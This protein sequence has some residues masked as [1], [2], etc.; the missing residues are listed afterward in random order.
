MAAASSG[1]APGHVHA[2][3]D[4]R[5]LGPGRLRVE[6]SGEPP[7]RLPDAHPFY[8]VFP[9]IA[10]P[11]PGH[12]G[13]RE[14]NGFLKAKLARALRAGPRCPRGAAPEGKGRSQ[15]DPLPLLKN[16][17][18]W[19]S[20][21][22]K[23]TRRPPEHHQN[24]TRRPPEDHLLV[25]EGH[26]SP[27]PV[28]E[29]RVAPLPVSGSGRVPPSRHPPPSAPRSAPIVPTPSSAPISQLPVSAL[30]R[31][32]TC[33]VLAAVTL[34]AWFGVTQVRIFKEY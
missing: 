17:R 27:G 3:S 4:L 23:T 31:S 2:P 19:K 25:P 1:H 24:T 16:Q 28:A 6:P 22:E 14:Q 5:L 21:V 33:P 30:R 34:E 12:R 32:H 13:W 20:V 7:H 10:A 15:L 8:E 9:V 18:T 29:G 26:F 11:F